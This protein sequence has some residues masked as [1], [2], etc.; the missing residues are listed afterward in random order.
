MKTCKSI[1]EEIN[2]EICKACNKNKAPVN[3]EYCKICTP[4]Y[5]VSVLK[6][7]IDRLYDNR[8]IT[9]LRNIK[10]PFIKG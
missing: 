8:E 7:L 1:I 5:G 4:I 10:S 6:I 2:R 9:E 3:K